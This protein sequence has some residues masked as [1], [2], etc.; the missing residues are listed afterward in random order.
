MERTLYSLSEHFDEIDLVYEKAEKNKTTFGIYLDI[1]KS[2]LAE[3][4]NNCDIFKDNGVTVTKEKFD[5]LSDNFKSMMIHE[6][7]DIGLHGFSASMEAPEI[8]VTLSEYSPIVLGCTMFSILNKIEKLD[9]TYNEIFPKA[10]LVIEAPFGGKKGLVK[11]EMMVMLLYP[12][13]SVREESIN[14]IATTAEKL[15]QTSIA[16]KPVPEK[17]KSKKTSIFQKLFGKK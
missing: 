11:L 8:R 12:W 10:S 2:A 3:A 13:L 4:E 6:L 5:S 7:S 1:E 17:T 15:S 14:L 16:N 9:G